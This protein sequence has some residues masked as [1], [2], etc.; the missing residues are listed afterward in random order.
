MFSKIRDYDCST[1]CRDVCVRGFKFNGSKPKFIENSS[2]ME[3]SIKEFYDIKDDF[4]IFKEKPAP[5]K[6][7]VKACRIMCIML[8]KIPEKDEYSDLTRFKGDKKYFY[9]K[10]VAKTMKTFD[11][12]TDILSKH[13]LNSLDVKDE[14][15]VKQLIASEEFKEESLKDENKIVQ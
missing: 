14:K 11:Q 5:S 7:D 9:S 12:F 6:L 13:D 3:N 2:D 8:N 10:T 4:K 15:K 1:Y